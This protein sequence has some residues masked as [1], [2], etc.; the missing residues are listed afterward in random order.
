ARPDQPRWATTSRFTPSAR[1]PPGASVIWSCRMSISRPFRLGAASRIAASIRRS[2]FSPSVSRL[3]RFFA[4]V[5]RHVFPAGGIRF[6]GAVVL[7]PG[8]VGQAVHLPEDRPCRLLVGN[9]RLSRA[10]LDGDD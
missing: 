7:H 2:S 9:L 4:A 5:L 8:L 6:H 10:R 3:L 1:S